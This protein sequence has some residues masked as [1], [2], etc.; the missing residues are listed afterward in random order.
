M[1]MT[2]TLGLITGLCLSFSSVNG[3]NKSIQ[4]NIPRL[5]TF[6]RQRVLLQT[7]G[8]WQPCMQQVYWCHVSKHVSLGASVSR[9]A[10]LNNISKASLVAQTVKVCLQCRRPGFNPWVRKTPWRRKWQ[11]TPVFLPGKFH[12]RRNIQS[13]VTVHGVAKS[14]TQLSN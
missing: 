1:L 10:F 2:V 9:L 3:D 11:P 4:L 8:V 6:H 5:I 13:T 12:G 7:A 14:R